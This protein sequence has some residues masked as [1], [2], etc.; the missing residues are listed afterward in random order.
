MKRKVNTHLKHVKMV[1]AAST[2][3]RVIVS[4]VN[5]PQCP[6]QGTKLALRCFLALKKLVRVQNMGLEP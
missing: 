1:E 2:E 5:S 3:N 6:G 4:S